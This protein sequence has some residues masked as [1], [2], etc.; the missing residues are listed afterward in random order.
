[1]TRGQAK[2]NLVK[3]GIA[4]P[5]EQQITD[6]LDSVAT[7]T[8]PLKE[9]AEKADELQTQ[10]DDI[11]NQS[12]SD[13]EKLQ[14]QIE[15]L[16]NSNRSLTESSLKSEAKAILKGSGL[17][18]ETI[19]AI[20][21]GMVA[22]LDKIEDVQARTNTYVSGV[23]KVLETKLKEKEKEDLDG[24][25]TPGGNNGDD[26]QGDEK[27]DAEKFAETVGNEAAEN[28]KATESIVGSYL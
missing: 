20:L 22:G 9:K 18:D 4:E 3:L 1:M 19:E 28:A 8:T 15:A 17:D 7:E 6:Y 25:G 12:L 16:E 26:G 21:P 23:N 5:T 27:T 24:T 11:Q 14:K 2:A 13:V 10:L